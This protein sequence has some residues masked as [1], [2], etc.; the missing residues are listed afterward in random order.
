MEINDII[1]VKT[2]NLSSTGDA[3]ARINEDKLVVFIQGALL[4]E[5]LKIKIISKNKHFLRG[6]IIEILE[7]SP[8][9]IKPFCALYNACGSC[10]FQIAEYNY[11]I[12]QKDKILKEIFKNV[13]DE[14]LI[15]P[16][17]K[18]PIDKE[19]R[20]KI[21][22]PCRQT[23]NSKRILMGYFKN[24]SH[25]LTNIKFCPVQPNIV[26]E[27]AQFIRDNFKLGCFDEKT[28]KG[29]LKNIVLR[30]NRAQDSILI[31]FVANI[32][33]KAFKNYEKD[34]S[35]FASDLINSFPVIKGVF[36][37][38]NP[39]NSNKILSN[40]TIKILGNDFIEETLENKRYNIGATSFFQIN[41]KSA[42]NLFNVVKDNVSDNS[43]VL[44]AYGGVG[45]IGIFVSDKAKK[46]T[47]VE[48]NENAIL[49]AK[50]NFKLNNIENYEILSGDAKKHFIDFKNDN[51][52][53]DVVILDPPRSGCDIAN[54]GL[55]IISSLTDKIIYVSCNPMT[56]K[57]DSEYL[58]SIGFK[59][60]S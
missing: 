24:N 44:D 37:N 21:Q 4:D 35:L 32:K 48:E 19:Y 29:F 53:F 16:F 11:Q 40:D 5:T 2:E 50:E 17:I 57:R 52:H 34:F 51:K 45:A 60:K 8:N 14:K 25:E 26:N 31:T 47:L 55:D 23:K 13:I 41:P 9:R 43:T 38:F 30:L 56:L 39:E 3:I 33:T 28:K 36:I 7:P 12:A 20:H 18:S 46:I 6:E 15:K 1:T 27:I 22:F 54:G 58:K 49:C 59:V 10:N 42:V